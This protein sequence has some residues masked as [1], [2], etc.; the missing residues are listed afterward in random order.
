MQYPAFSTALINI[1]ILP[2]A[3]LISVDDFSPTSRDRAVF[4]AGG[5]EQALCGKN[6]QDCE[7]SEGYL[8]VIHAAPNSVI[9][10]AAISNFLVFRV[11]AE[12]GPIFGSY[13]LG[14]MK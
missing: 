7:S 13:Q 14:R 11:R 12:K 2:K 4:E 1:E 6:E 10:Y 3:G 8:T 5:G 9:F